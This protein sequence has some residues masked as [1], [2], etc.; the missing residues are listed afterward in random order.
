VITFMTTFA[1]LL[2]AAVFAVLGRP[3]WVALAFAVAQ[4]AFAVICLFLGLIGEQ[5]RLISEISRNTP[6]VIEKERVNFPN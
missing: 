3:A 2:C 4:G 1:T 5:V 6:L